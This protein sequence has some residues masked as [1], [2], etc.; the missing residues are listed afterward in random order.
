MNRS[1]LILMKTIKTVVGIV[2]ARI[3]FAGKG[4]RKSR[5]R[6]KKKNKNKKIG[7][8]MPQKIPEAFSKNSAFGI[9]KINL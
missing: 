4:K 1:R 9:F 3:M 5:K 6:V 7:T 8:I 2:D